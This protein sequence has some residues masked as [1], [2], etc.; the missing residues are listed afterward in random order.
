[1]SLS[2]LTVSLLLTPPSICLQAANMS[3]VRRQELCHQPLLKILPRVT[4]IHSPHSRGQACE[5]SCDEH[6]EHDGA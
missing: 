4:T 1:M 2:V 6:E 3:R 5:R